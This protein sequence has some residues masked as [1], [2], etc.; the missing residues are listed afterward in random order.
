[1][2]ELWF[3]ILKVQNELFSLVLMAESRKYS[4]LV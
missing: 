2:T 4:I 3:V 1:M